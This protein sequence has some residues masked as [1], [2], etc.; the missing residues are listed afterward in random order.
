MS[1]PSKN[2]STIMMQIDPNS[3]ASEAYRSLRFY[4][5]STA[6]DQD[7]KTIAITS[8]VRGEGKTTTAMNLA[9]AY[10][11][12][13]KRILLIDADLRNPSIHH[14]FGGENNRGLSSYLT[15]Q[16]SVSD[17]IRISH[18]ENLSL[19]LSGPVP[20]NPAELLASR[21]MEALLAQLKQSYDMIFI[22]TSSVLTLT[23]G[24]IIAAQCDGVL[25]VVEYGSLKRNVAKRVKEDLMLAKAKL[26]GVVMNKMKDA[27]AYL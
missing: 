16:C 11:Q 7:L 12:I 23:D 1:K 4:M 20:A 24:K 10:A 21:Q 25:L 3:Q 5:E 2:H 26:M 14:A 17:M 27:E 13:G 19:I 6:K 18:I 22:D 15:G 9:T 8:A